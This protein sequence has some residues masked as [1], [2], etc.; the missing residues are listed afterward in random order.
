MTQF[1]QTV[2]VAELYVRANFSTSRSLLEVSYCAGGSPVRFVGSESARSQFH[3]AQSAL[4]EV[5][6]EGV[7]ALSEKLGVGNHK[8]PALAAQQP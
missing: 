5:R 2:V 6:I 8:Q 1:P 7:P 3:E 4:Q